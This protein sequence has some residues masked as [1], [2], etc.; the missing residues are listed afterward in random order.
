MNNVL[1]VATAFESSRTEWNGHYRSTWS[2][3]SLSRA[4]GIFP[5]FL[6][7]HRSHRV[8][9]IHWIQITFLLWYCP[10]AFQEDALEDKGNRLD[11]IA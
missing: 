6:M 5:S 8:R 9:C 1:F 3:N 2:R 10:M 4:T 11:A 7:W